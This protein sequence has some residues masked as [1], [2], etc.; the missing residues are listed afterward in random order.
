MA[1]NKKYGT[2]TETIWKRS[3]HIY[4]PTQEMKDQWTSIADSRNQSFSKFVI[5]QVTNS[6]NHEKEN[7]SYETRLNLIKEKE[8]LENEN[9]QLMKQLKDKEKLADYWEKETRSQNTKPFLEQDFE[10]DR[11]FEKDLINLFKKENDVRKEK[12][13]KKLHV[14]VMDAIIVSA[15]QKQIQTLESYGIIKDTGA[16]W[17]W[18]L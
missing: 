13:Y 3:M 15:I 7:P 2:K 9:R 14:D 6:L 16:F 17:R 1:K 12:I 18:T 4:L 5:E 10:G 11:G 8:K